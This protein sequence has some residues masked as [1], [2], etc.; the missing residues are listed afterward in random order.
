MGQEKWQGNEVC[1]QMKATEPVSL[2]VKWRNTCQLKEIMWKSSWQNAWHV[3]VIQSVFDSKCE[4]ERL[5]Q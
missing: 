2:S 4:L 5:P 3:I 1:S